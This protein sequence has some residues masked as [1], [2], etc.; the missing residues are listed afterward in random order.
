M[1]SFL[2]ELKR[3]NVVRVAILYAIVG[4]LVLQVAAL[5]IPALGIPD[6]AVSLAVVLVALGFPIALILAWAYELTPGG[7]KRTH[8]VARHQSITRLTGRKLDFLIIGVLAAVLMFVLAKDYVARQ[9]AAVSTVAAPP[10]AGPETATIA[11][12]P[13][14]DMSPAKDQEYLTDGMSEELLNALAKVEG[15]RVAART[16][17][18]AFKGRSEDL[19]EVGRKLGVENILEGSI[20]KQGDRIRVTAQ[21]VKAQDGL[22]LWS[23]TY[24]RKLDDVFAIEDEIAQQVVGAIRRALGNPVDNTVTAAS[25]VQPPTSSTEAYI[26]YLRG[27]HRLRDRSR[28]G[29]EAALGEF[30]RAVELDPRFALAHVGI[31][32]SLLLQSSYRQRS[33]SD[34]QARVAGELKRA[35]G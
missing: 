7:I 9:G 11:V 20:R 21:L 16:S 14:I 22:H 4:W 13:F 24:D 32:N 30:E 28:Q 25:D 8:E 1:S 23:E 2:G 19:R 29:M 6:W 31:A 3:R 35:R 34:L 17:A 18:F 12:L 33:L 10:T 15:F 26:H 27:Q 5:V